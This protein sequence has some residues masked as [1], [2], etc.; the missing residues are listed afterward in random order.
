ML[1]NALHG[2]HGH[3]RWPRGR[4]GWAAGIQDKGLGNGPLLQATET[5]H[6]RL[7]ARPHVSAGTPGC[8]TVPPKGACPLRRLHRPVWVGRAPRGTRLPPAPCTPAAGGPRGCLPVPW[9]TVPTRVAPPPSAGL[10]GAP[11]SDASGGG[12]FPRYVGQDES[13]TKEISF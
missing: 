5:L 6:S 4:S 13:M 10:R 11:G 7:C 3:G 9:E 1:R 12:I 2:V 8:C